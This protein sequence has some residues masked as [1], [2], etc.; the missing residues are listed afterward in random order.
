MNSSAD[1]NAPFS[2]VPPLIR[3]VPSLSNVQVGKA[4]ALFRF[5]PLLNLFVLGLNISVVLLYGNPPTKA[6][7]SE[8]EFSH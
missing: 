5:G 3:T 8:V 4:R 2:P 6:M 1:R 7:Q